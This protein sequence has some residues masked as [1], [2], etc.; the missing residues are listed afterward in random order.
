MSQEYLDEVLRIAPEQDTHLCYIGG[1]RSRPDL[2]TEVET[3]KIHSEEDREVGTTS[4]TSPT[5]NSHLPSPTPKASFLYLGALTASYD[6]DTLFAAAVILAAEDHDFHIHIAGSGP[7]EEKLKSES[8]NRKLEG[9]ITFHGF[10]KEAEMNALCEICDVGLNIIQ[11]GLHITMPHKL[12]DYLCTGLAVINSLSGEAE[13]LLDT[14][15][16]GLTYPAGN[17]IVLAKHMRTYILT[18]DAKKAAQ[19]AAWKLAYG[20]FNR[21][22]SYPRWV[23]WGLK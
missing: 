13:L 23:G 9:V 2:A 3:T 11:A 1:R 4:P 5:S 19:K 21:E 18:P 8:G 14:S 7:L 6:F 17:A 12:N 16:A 15:G 20:Q 10:L 22:V